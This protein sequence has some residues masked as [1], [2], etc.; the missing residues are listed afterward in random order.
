MQL[1]VARGPLSS[2]VIDLLAGREVATTEALVQ[3]VR[4][5]PDDIDLLTDDDFHLALWVMYELHYAGFEDVE[6]DLEWDP[7]LIRLR[8]EMEALFEAEL[9]R[10]AEPHVSSTMAAAGDL[11]QRLFDL[12]ATFEGP[13]VARFV[14]R[15]ASLEQFLELMVHRSIYHLKESDPHNW[16]IPRITGRPKAALVEL[17]YDEFGGGRPE[18]LH[19][20]MFGDSLE[21]CGLDREYGAYVDQVPGY[22]L[23]SNNAMSLLGLHRRLRGAAM[24][25]LGAFEATSSIPCRKYAGGVRRLGLPEV[26]AAY[27]D[28]HIEADAVHEQ[29][30]F[31]DICAGLVTSGQA[32][33]EDVVLGVT[34]CL[35][36][37]VVVGERMLADWQAGRST[38]LGGTS[39][40]PTTAPVEA[41]AS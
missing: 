22:T 10:R 20:T 41:V 6:P 29:L 3:L 35:L 12:T 27:F 32:E 14:H 4:E 30:A 11:A 15:E 2:G 9:R 34:I 21:G 37:D 39:P 36:M 16:V 5:L 40:R 1:P 13:S 26:V 33:E 8:R 24:G 18:R 19:A 28:E 25:H 38:L 7:D 17:Q 23:A 31:R